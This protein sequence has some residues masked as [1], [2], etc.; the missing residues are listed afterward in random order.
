VPYPA[1]LND[2]L[3]GLKWLHAN[4]ESLG[5]DSTRIVV[6]GESGGANLAIACLLALKRKGELELVKGLYAL[7]PCLA[8]MWSDGTYPSS[9]KNNGLFINVRNNRHAMGYGIEAYHAR[10]P[11]TC[12]V[13][14]QATR[15]RTAAD[16]HQ[17]Q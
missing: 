4:A 1:D 7:C 5:I 11:L 6:G 16:G 9:I 8:G 15:H 10:D 13:R 17:C 3:S 2:C 12:E 14:D